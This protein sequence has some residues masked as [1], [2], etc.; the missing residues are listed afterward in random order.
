MLISDSTG[1]K[2]ICHAAPKQ[3]SSR[4]QTLLPLARCLHKTIVYRQ[5][6]QRNNVSMIKIS[7]IETNLDYT[8]T[9]SLSR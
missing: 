4:A 8:S 5:K 1:L 9:L 3:N 6:Q 2:K 7:K